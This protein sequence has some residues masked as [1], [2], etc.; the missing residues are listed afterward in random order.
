MG[1]FGFILFE[2][3]CSWDEASFEVIDAYLAGKPLKSKK[4]KKVNKD[5]LFWSSKVIWDF[6]AEVFLRFCCR[7]VK[8]N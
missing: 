4:Q 1:S 7:S 8:I 3:G 2:K 6:S 5:N